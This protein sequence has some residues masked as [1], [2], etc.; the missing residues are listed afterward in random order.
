[1]SATMTEEERRRL[2]E[3]AADSTY[4][5]GANRATIAH[6][7]EVFRRYIRPG[8]ILEMGPAEGYMTGDLASLDEP[9]TVVEGA[10]VFCDSIKARWPQI[11]VVHALFEE[12]KPKQKFRS[13][14][15][16][17]V[18]EHVDDPV[19]ILA[20]AREWLTDD[21]RILAAVPNARSLHRQAAVIMGML[22]FEEAL[23]EADHKHGHRRVYNPETFRRDFMQAGLSIEVFG[24]YWMK[25]VSNGQ[26]ERDW[27]PEM[28]QAFMVLGERYP[29]IAGEIYVV[30]QRR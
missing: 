9:L 27:T 8:P 10:K 15:L 20:L 29:D 7:F 2:D 12:F 3:I 5:A 18:L 17:H 11:E 24:G 14:V 4:G 25:P 19:G 30:A 28:L 21:G 13:I 23:N 6:S 16:G 26:I 22:P 1:M